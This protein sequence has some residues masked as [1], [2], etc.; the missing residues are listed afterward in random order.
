MRSPHRLHDR[1]SFFKYMPASTAKLVLANTSLRWSSHVLF[2]DP[3]DV[4]RELSFGITPKEIAEAV[5][6]RFASLIE[7]PPQDTS[8]LRPDLAMVI[9]AV[10]GGIPPEVRE[11]VLAAIN[12]PHDTQQLAAAMEGLRTLWRS[13]IPDFRILCLTE[14][15]THAAMWLHYADG[16]KGAVLEFNCDDEADSAWLQAEPVTYPA[17]KPEIFEADGWANLM[18]MPL[19][20]ATKT[21]LH[22]S[23]FTKA[24]DWSYEKEWRVTSSKRRG[25]SGFFTDYQFHTKEL[26]TVYLGPLMPADDKEA[27]IALTRKYPQARVFEVA[28][29]MSREFLLNRV[30]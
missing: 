28:I 17:H 18:M 11:E 12:E 7:Q 2:N 13:W 1:A 30:G 21:I 19:Y 29:G 25:D 15:A 27:L 6:R 4:P 24:P 10:K 20:Q 5:I 16:Y 9:D 23:T 26:A 8:V 3:F 22:V 14:S